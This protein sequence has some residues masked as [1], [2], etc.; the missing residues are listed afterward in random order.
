MGDEIPEW[1]TMWGAKV[2]MP[3]DMPDDMLKDAI[4]TS[5]KAL[6]ECSNFE[7]DGLEVAENIKKQFD[8]RWSPYW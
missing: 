5:Q 1:Q 2:K 7:A 4:E 8:D 3:V 6:D